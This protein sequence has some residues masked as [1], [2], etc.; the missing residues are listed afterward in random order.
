MTLSPNSGSNPLKRLLPMT[1]GLLRFALIEQLV[2]PNLEH[3][4]GGIF[5][6]TEIW[7]HRKK[8]ALTT[9]ESE[10]AHME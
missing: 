10:F 2:A 9:I 8:E 4:R 1:N 7:L 6:D 3:I 5:H